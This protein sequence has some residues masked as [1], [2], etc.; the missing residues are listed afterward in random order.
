LSPAE[1]AA[2][3][4]RLDVDFGGEL[5]LLGYHLRTTAAA[6]G[7]SVRLTLFWQSQIA[8]D[9]NWSVFVHLVDQDDILVAQRDRY[10]GQ[11]LLATTLLQ[12]GQTWADDYVIALPAGAFSPATLRVRVGVYDLSDG[13]RLP[14]GAA[15]EW[16]EFGQVALAGRELATRLGPVPNALRQSFGG[17]IELAGYT[18]D[19]RV[20]RPGETL[21]VTLYWRALSPIPANYSVSARVRG[22]RSEDQTRWAAQDPWPQAGQA[23]TSAWRVGELLADPYA[24]TLAAATPPGQYFVEI[25]IYDSQTLRPLPLWTDDGRPTDAGSLL[26]TRVRVTP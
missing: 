23:P 19:R 7:G 20:L 26:L 22:E 6:P 3:P 17:Q 8:M 4:Q 24:L 18:L 12:P 5:Q 9:R 2:I 11:G 13:V 15:G 10:P 1:L 16:A 14:A 25:V 21:T